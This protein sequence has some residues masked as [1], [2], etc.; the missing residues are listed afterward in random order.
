MANTGQL[1]E[2][3]IGDPGYRSTSNIAASEQN[4]LDV[5]LATNRQKHGTRPSR[6]PAPRDL[7][8]RGLDRFL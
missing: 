8:A 7:D 6:G 5:C 4:G 3:L 2:K 1:P